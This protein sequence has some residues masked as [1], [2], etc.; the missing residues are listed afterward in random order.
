MLSRSRGAHFA[1]ERS[2]LLDLRLLALLED[3]HTQ[4]KRHERDR[5][6]QKNEPERFHTRRV[7]L[8][9]GRT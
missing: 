2:V 3:H 4:A 7:R 9:G 6:D 5:R 1:L 8:A